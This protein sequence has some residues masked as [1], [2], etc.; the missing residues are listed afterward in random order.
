MCMGEKLQICPFYRLRTRGGET[1]K[2][3][4]MGVEL[5]LSR[6]VIPEIWEGSAGAV[7]RCL[8]KALK[9]RI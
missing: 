3:P 9:E 4:R 2:R 7:R 6:I 8:N 5:D 1:I